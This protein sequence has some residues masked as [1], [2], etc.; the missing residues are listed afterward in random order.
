MTRLQEIAAP[1]AGVDDP[2]LPQIGKYRFLRELAR[3]AMGI[4]YEAEDTELRRPVAVKVLKDIPG[5]SDTMH[6]RFQREA[7]S[8]A[9]LAHPNV[10]QVY[11]SGEEE[12]SVYLVMELVR[13]RPLSEILGG[14]RYELRPMLELLEKASRGVAAAHDA[15]IVHRDVKPANVLVGD[16]G[17]PKVGDFGLARWMDSDTLLTKSG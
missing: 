15:G 16:N 11:D 12:G 10:V 1:L 14:R 17:I 9:R 5:A 3:G 13:G 7:R 6:Q 8:A 4:V 2:A